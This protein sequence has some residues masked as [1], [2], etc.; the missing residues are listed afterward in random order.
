[1]TAAT[2]LAAPRPAEELGLERIFEEVRTTGMAGLAILNERLRVEAVGFRE[3]RGVRVGAL[4]T[5]W[6][7]NLMIVAAPGQ[8]LAAL[9]TGATECWSF[10]SGDY[11]FYGHTEASIGHYR[12]C[13]LISPV[14]EFKS[15]ADAVAAA[16]AALAAL[17]TPPEPRR[18]SRRGLLGGG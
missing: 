18:V 7:V 11:D 15:H 1:M 9:P 6:S 14:L 10:P 4:V 16:R 12:Q 13:S 8:A 3:W 5:P 2:S 17:F